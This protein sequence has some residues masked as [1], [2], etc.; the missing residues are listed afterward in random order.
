MTRRFRTVAE[1]VLDACAAD[2]PEWALELGDARWSDKLSDFSVTADARR[3]AVLTDALGSLDE[4]DPDLLAPEDLVDLEMLRSEISAQLWRT[5]ELRPH[6]WDPLVHSPGKAFHALLESDLLPMPERLDALTARCGLLPEYLATARDRLSEGPGMSRVHVETALAQLEEARELFSSAV[7]DLDAGGGTRVEAACAAASAALEEHTVWMRGQLDMAFADPRLGE[8]V[9]SAQLW[10]TLD[11]EI[12]AQTLLLRAESDLLAVEESI[13]EV[14]AEYEDAPRRPGQVFDVLFGLAT[15]HAVDDTGFRTACENALT[16]LRE[17]VRE[18]DLVTVYDDPIRVVPLPTTR[19][20]PTG[21]HCV[22]PGPLDPRVRELPVD[23]TVAAPPS[24]HP[25][26]PSFFRAHNALALRELMAHEAVPGHALQFSHAIRHRGRT[27]VRT[28]L[29]NA[30]FVGGWAARAAER[31]AAPGRTD[32]GGGPER[33][34]ELGARLV[35]LKTRLRTLIDTILDVRVHA[36]DITETEAIAL[37]TERGHQERSEA[38]DKWRRVQVAGA[39]L[40]THY[41]GHL[42]LSEIARELATERPGASERELHDAM[43]AH[44]S[45]APRHLRTLLGLDPARP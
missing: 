23:V 2:A 9:H 5:A 40:S 33:R 16:R 10:Y 37:M 26:G 13:A 6:T 11:S 38:V 32:R 43:L 8:R 24:G 15:S 1:R 35:Q 20:G 34:D 4:I 39:Q 27:R 29:H 36:K 19:R 41:A 14:A 31:L 30:S 17:R 22:P 12:S 21:V 25:D 45:P 3:A 28:V 18:S 42:E 7:S 44:G